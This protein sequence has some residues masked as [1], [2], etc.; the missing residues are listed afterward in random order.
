MKF[1][2]ALAARTSA[3]RGA[4]A[5]TSASGAAW[6]G[7][8][9]DSCQAALLQTGIDF[10]GDGSFDAWWEWIPDDV[11]FLGNFA[12]SVG[13]V[14]YMEVDA[15][16]ETTGVAVL[17]NKTTG[18][19]ATHTFARTPSTLCETDAERIVEDF[20]D[21]LAG[22]SEIVFTQT[23]RPCRR[24]ASSRPRAVLSSTWPRKAPG[25]WRRTVATVP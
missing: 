7:I 19:K 11:V 2:V 20:A 6:V 25:R 15:S 12:L 9:G 21:N 23:T 17:E 4:T 13:D 22:F 10:Y 8:D 14:I 18:E 24:P 16:S 1:T 5:P 3:R